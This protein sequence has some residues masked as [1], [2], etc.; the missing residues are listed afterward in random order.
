MSTNFSY[1]KENRDDATAITLEGTIDEDTTLDDVFADTKDNVNIDISK[2]NH[3][4]SCG[5]RTW[6]H[7]IEELSSSKDVSFIN[8]SITM[9]RQ[10]NM[11]SNFGGNG[12]VKSFIIPYFCEQCDKEYEFTLSKKEYL[13]KYPGLDAPGFECPSC[14]NALEF[15]DLED[16]YFHFLK[17]YK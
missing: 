8:C 10:F 1:S 16:K 14:K 13:E 11:I 15:D 9:V 6:V 3:I 12:V 5:I 7:A 17:E 2:I 4:N